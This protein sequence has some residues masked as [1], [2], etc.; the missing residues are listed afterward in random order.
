MKQMS[1][2]E[3]KQAEQDYRKRYEDRRNRRHKA[4]AIGKELTKIMHETN[5]RY[6]KKYTEASFSTTLV[7]FYLLTY[8]HGSIEKVKQST[9]S[10]E[11]VRQTFMKLPY[12][13][14]V[15]ITDTMMRGYAFAQGTS[16]FVYLKGKEI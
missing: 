16:M 14:R 2:E 7:K 6:T 1:T 5:V 11:E 10:F 12:V 4:I 8:N 3:A 9:A 15:V 13:E